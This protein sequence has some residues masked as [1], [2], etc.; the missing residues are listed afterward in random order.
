MRQTSRDAADCRVARP[1]EEG[2]VSGL[3]R[4]AFA[5]FSIRRRSATRRLGPYRGRTCTGK[6]IGAFLDT[7]RARH[8]GKLSAAGATRLPGSWIAPPA[9]AGG[10]RAPPPARGWRRGAA[11]GARGAGAPPGSAAGAHRVLPCLFAARYVVRLPVDGEDHFPLPRTSR[12]S[13]RGGNALTRPLPPRPAPPLQRPESGR[14]RP[15]R[16]GQTAAPEI[17]PWG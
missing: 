1:P 12:A 4:G 9:P 6:P 15:L 3:R 5:P 14:L 17:L 2:F 16:R 13:A 10:G 8:S 11:A 7:P